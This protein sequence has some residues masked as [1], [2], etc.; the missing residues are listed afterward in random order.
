VALEIALSQ[1][2]VDRMADLVAA[3]GAALDESDTL[4]PGL[5]WWLE[6]LPASGDR[7]S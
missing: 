1:R 4:R 6:A 3:A 5:N 2:R 7:T